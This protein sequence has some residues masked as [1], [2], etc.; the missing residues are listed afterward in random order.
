MNNYAKIRALKIGSRKSFRIFLVAE[1]FLLLV[2]IVGF[3]GDNATY[4]YSTEY[5]STDSDEAGYVVEFADISLPRGV[6][7]VRL[8]YETDTDLLN[9]CTVEDVSGAIGN[10]CTNG[11]K[12]FSGLTR[13]DFTMWLSNPSRIAVRVWYA[14]EGKLAVQ[15]LSIEK[16]HAGDRIF[17]CKL[18][19][20]F[21][22]LNIVYLYLQYDRTYG[23]PRK[24][25]AVTFCLGLTIFAASLPVMVDYIVG[26][27]DLVY[28]L[29]R[30]EGIKD[31]L[32]G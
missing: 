4:E 7:Q 10:V 11:T 21:T 19:C 6:Y 20:L 22:V 28:H 1:I 5:A 15:G 25:K 27:G 16:T 26:S 3:F 14:G 32:G 18:L 13:T 29:M 31:A 17:M 8:H 23:I 24:N 12:L 2:G 30:I 9:S